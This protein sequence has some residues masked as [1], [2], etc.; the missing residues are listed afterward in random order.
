MSGFLFALSLCLLMGYLVL[1]WHH[2]GHWKGYPVLPRSPRIEHLLLGVLLLAH[3]ALVLLPVLSGGYLDL[4]LGRALSALVW[5]MLLIYW[6][7]SFFYRVEGLQLLML[8]LAVLALGFEILLPGQH[9]SYEL[10]N[11]LFA[12][13]LLVSMLAY[14]L[15]AI[16]AL[17][18]MLMLVLDR[19]LHAR[20]GTA[21]TR[22]LPPLLSLESM[23]FQVIAAGFALL[24]V[25]LVT[26]ILFSE[27]MFGTPLT[28]NHKIV[29]A[30]AAWLVFG[31]LLLGRVRRGWRGRLAVRWILS[32]FSLL[33]LGY[34]GSKIVLELLLGR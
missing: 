23:M 18:A 4:G 19:A 32:G 33:L 2:L 1:S 34:I 11:P 26:G 16:A 20:R 25:S 7:S 22:Q 8:P 29:F 17:L 3:A 15:F 13:H 14:S 12:L 6:T 5:L 21:F 31:S 24:S 9:I 30:C 27:Q 10:A 28:L